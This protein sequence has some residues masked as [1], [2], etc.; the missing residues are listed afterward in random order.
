MTSKWKSDS[1]TVPKPP[2]RGEDWTKT[3]DLELDIDAKIKEVDQ[4]GITNILV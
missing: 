1:T 3:K 4:E 2:S